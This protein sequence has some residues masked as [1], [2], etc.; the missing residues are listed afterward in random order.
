MPQCEKTVI[1]D[2]DE[3]NRLLELQLDINVMENTPPYFESIVKKTFKIENNQASRYELP[4][5]LDK[6]GNANVKILIAETD[7]LENYYPSFVKVNGLQ[8]AINFDP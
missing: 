4:K 7:G 1:R 8:N 3:Q 5:I 6:E 2:C